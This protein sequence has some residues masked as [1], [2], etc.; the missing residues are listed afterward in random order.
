MRVELELTREQVARLR[1]AVDQY[2][3]IGRCADLIQI[4]LT[5]LP[6]SA[7]D[8]PSA[9]ATPVPS[10]LTGAGVGFSLHA[11]TPKGRERLPELERL[12]SRIPHGGDL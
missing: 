4:L 8:N 6:E 2:L 1:H 9:G 12:L 11:L 7:A 3:P 5:Q 10:A